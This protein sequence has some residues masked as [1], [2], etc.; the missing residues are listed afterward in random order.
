MI[1]LIVAI[2]T[3]N[4]IAKGGKIPWT[5]KEDL[6]E[7]KRIT[8]GKGNNA[9]IMGR[10]TWEGIGGNLKRRVNFVIGKGC[11]YKSL[12]HALIGV[13]KYHNTV[14]KIDEVFII[15][16]KRLY[17][18]AFLKGI[19][20]KLYIT[21]VIHDFECD[22][23]ID[24][25]IS[26]SVYKNTYQSE[27]RRDGVGDG[28]GVEYQ[29]FEYV[30]KLNPKTSFEYSEVDRLYLCDAMVHEED[31]Y[32]NILRQILHSGTIKMDRTGVGTKFIFGTQMR[33]DLSNGSFPLLTTKRVFFRG[34]VE[35]LLWIFRGNTDAK[36]L[37]AKG[38]NI[39]NQNSTKE[40]H[41]SRGLE[42]FEEGDCGAI[43]GH[44]LRHFG[45]EY[46]DCKSVYEGTDQLRSLIKE[47][48][49][50]PNSRRLVL[51]MWDPA[52]LKN[53]VLPPCHVLYQFD[54]VN[55]K[56]SCSMYQRSGDM[57]LGVPFNIASTSLLL[58]IIANICRLEVGEVVHT[59]ANA[60]IY[61]TH[62]EA[63]EEQLWRD[64]REFPKLEILK[65]LE[66]IEDIEQMEFSD[67]KLIGYKPHP[68]IKAE[69]AV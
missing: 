20:N 1:S 18:E 64:P 52:S 47:I 46:V 61:L 3:E 15:G 27:V 62:I 8:I 5:I 43:Y 39:W 42:R 49:E 31:Q 40:F 44:N 50:N 37:A 24:M 59:I 2:D 28:E 54:I 30:N 25:I 17:E 14:K 4:G 22:L 34:V 58:H 57:F 11:G 36:L 65:R 32:L 6:K 21:E 63:V 60:H 33:F 38:V 67:F 29:F 56:I 26:S 55:G 68:T 45:A 10:K 12:E 41:A 51:N 9:V 66:T 69:M 7:F 13:R 53:A 35:E 19:C 23:K 48:K 16:G